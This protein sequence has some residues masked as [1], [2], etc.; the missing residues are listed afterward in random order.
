MPQD[1]PQNQRQRQRRDMLRLMSALPLLSIPLP[2][3]LS[4]SLLPVASAS[5]GTAVVDGTLGGHGYFYPPVL[6]PDFGVTDHTGKH[7]SFRQ[8]LH[9]HISLVQL[10]FTSCS[11]VCPIQGA[12]FSQLQELIPAAHRSKVQLLSITIDPL[13]D[14]P[15]A[16]AAWLKQFNPQPMWKALRPDIKA[17]DTVRQLLNQNKTDVNSHLSEVLLVDASSKLVWRSSELPSSEA[18]ADKVLALFV[19]R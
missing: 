5:A 15:E 18:L 4:L 2:L 19:K 3:S 9:G 10:I 13:N 7:A 6:L 16:L 1:Q 11:N 14:N 17:I 8:I 12:T